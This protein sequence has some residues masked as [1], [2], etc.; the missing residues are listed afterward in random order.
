MT[1]REY[2]SN[3]YMQNVSWFKKSRRLSKASSLQLL[4]ITHLSVIELKVLKDALC[5]SHYDVDVSHIIVFSKEGINHL[6]LNND[7]I[8]SY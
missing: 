1:K 5:D 2:V 3:L 4:P 8:A 6:N 7:K